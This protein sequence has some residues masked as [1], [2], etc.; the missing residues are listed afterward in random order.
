MLLAAHLWDCVYVGAICPRRHRALVS[1]LRGELDRTQEDR[2]DGVPGSERV[3][4]SPALPVE[5]AA[6][7][8]T[9]AY[10]QGADRAGSRSVEE[11]HAIGVHIP[12]LRVHRADLGVQ[13]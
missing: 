13:G 4:I 6:E 12:N 2:P 3:W 11:V 7:V 1:Q 10:R 5:R 9:R 8:R